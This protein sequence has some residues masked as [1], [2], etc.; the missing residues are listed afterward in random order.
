MEEL[1]P[2]EAP[3]RLDA[4][5]T[6]MEL[7][8]AVQGVRKYGKDFQAI[9]ELVGTKTEGHVRS[10]WITYDSRYNLESVYAEWLHDQKQAEATTAN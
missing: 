8:L 7:L 4:R 9:A 10:F 5:W 2:A 6:N 3:G 1:R